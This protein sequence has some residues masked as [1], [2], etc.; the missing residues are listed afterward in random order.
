M[1]EDKLQQFSHSI[2]LVYVKKG[3]LLYNNLEKFFQEDQQRFIDD[4]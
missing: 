1:N 3:I 4:S 2:S